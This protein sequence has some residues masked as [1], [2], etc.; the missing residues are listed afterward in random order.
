MK[1]FLTQDGAKV[2]NTVKIIKDSMKEPE[3]SPP[4]EQ[5]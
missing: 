1:E 5:D 4:K 2:G 3:G